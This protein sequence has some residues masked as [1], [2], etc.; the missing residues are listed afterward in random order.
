MTETQIEQL[1]QVLANSS[2][3]DNSAEL[4]DAILTSA[5]QAVQQRVNRDRHVGR[6]FDLLPI[7]FLRT[8]SLAI[9][10]T[11]AV[12]L[13][14]G[15]LVSVDQKTIKGNNIAKP[16]NPSAIINT[17]TTEQT[18]AT[19]TPRSPSSSTNVT[20]KPL[21]SG[22]SRDQILLNFE[23]SDAEELLATLSFEFNQSSLDRN[24]AELAMVDINSLIHIG[25][26][27]N[28]RKRYGD[29]INRCVACGL[30]ET[31]EDLVLAAHNLAIKNSDFETG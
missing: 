10:L 28:A 11:I 15:Q 27:D 2:L 13:G 3:P 21:P 16:S 17:V 4:D 29:F 26:L 8:A 7:A 23:L 1:K 9:V 25:E 14:M 18:I 22:L 24:R 6:L 31:L 12:F 5:H 20:L 30:P 19:G